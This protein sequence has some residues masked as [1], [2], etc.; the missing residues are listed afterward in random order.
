MYALKK[1]HDAIERKFVNKNIFKEPINIISQKNDIHNKRQEYSIEKK[2]QSP[3]DESPSHESPSDESSSDESLSDDSS[4]DEYLLDESLSD[5]SLSDES[6]YEE[7]HTNTIYDYDGEKFIIDNEKFLQKRFD[8]IEPNKEY[9]MNMCIYKC[10]RTGCSPYLLYLMIYDESTKTYILP[11]YSNIL[12]GSQ[13]DNTDEVEESIINKFKES[14]FEIYPPSKYESLEETTDL[15][16]EELYK[17]FFLHENELTMV[18]D[19][20]RINVPLASNKYHWTSPYEIFVSKKIKSIPISTTVEKIFNEITTSSSNPFDFYHLKRSSNNSLVKTPYVLFMCKKSESTGSGFLL[21][22]AF[23]TKK[24]TYE[25]VEYSENETIIFPTIQNE[26]LGNYTFF[27]SFPFSQSNLVKRFAV[28]VDTDELTPLYVEPN[29]DDKLL[30]L[31][32][33]DAE[34]YS[35]VTFIE[36]DVQLWCIKSPLYFSEI[37]DNSIEENITPISIE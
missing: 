36:N 17:G 11:K 25:T 32:D 21:F 28:F 29:D 5:E 10:V 34:Q 13:K 4:L 26:N 33:V 27:S 16:D 1:T 35:S 2:Q 31:Y 22:D 20:T 14:L 30:H 6:E 18:H 24:T 19:A 8:D 3:S 7:I 37:I 23:N 15:Y 12:E 9:N